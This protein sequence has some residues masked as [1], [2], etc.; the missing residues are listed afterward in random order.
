MKAVNGTESWSETH[1]EIVAGIIFHIDIEGTVPNTIQ[2]EQGTGGLY[3]LA[4]DLTDEFELKHKGRQWDG[5]FFD[6]LDE[7]LEIKLSNTG[8]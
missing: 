2:K 3:E 8:S 4:S 5:E 6:E 7:F 1:Y